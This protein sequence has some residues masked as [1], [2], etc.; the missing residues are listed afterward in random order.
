MSATTSPQLDVFIERGVEMLLASTDLFPPAAVQPPVNGLNLV[1]TVLA[2]E[3]P[4]DQSPNIG[5]VPIIYVSYSKN[6]IGEMKYIGRDTLDE[7]GPRRYRLEFYNVIITRGITKEASM[8]KCQQLSNIVRDIYQKNLR[9][10]KPTDA[11]DF[12]ANTNEVIA[13]PFILR[14]DNVT[15]QAINVICRPS[16]RV[17]LRT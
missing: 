9:M 3:P 13:V 11:N 1:T 6:P 17:N 10:K 15:L 7:A 5:V 2:Q 14:T 4:I 8:K 12:I 16:V